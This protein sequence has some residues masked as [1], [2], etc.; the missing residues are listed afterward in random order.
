MSMSRRVLIC[1]DRDW[2]DAEMIHAF[3]ATLPAGTVVIN[4]GQQGAD[5]HANFAALSCGL[6]TIRMDAPWNHYGK[7]AGPI[8]NSWMLSYGQ[9]T[10]VHYFHDDI[11]R[12]RG[13]K[14]MVE[15]AEKAGLPVIPHTHADDE[16]SVA[17]GRR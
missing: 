16:A 1:G 9:P 2:A 8:R 4:G 3:V 12:S 11:A 17:I 6:P 10:E 14:D 5:L 15:R 13:T 7:R